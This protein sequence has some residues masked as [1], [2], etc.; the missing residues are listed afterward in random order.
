MVMIHELQVL[1]EVKGLEGKFPLFSRNMVL[2]LT[3][4]LI[5]MN[6]EINFNCL[7]QLK[8]LLQISYLCWV[9]PLSVRVSVGCAREKT[10]LMLDTNRNTF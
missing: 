5:L 9:R 2:Q 4:I 3:I 7:R 8:W 10:W 6:L 1:Q